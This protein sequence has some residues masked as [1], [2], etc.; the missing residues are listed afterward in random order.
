MAERKI[1]LEDLPSN[2]FSSQPP[3]EPEPII[4]VTTG[5]VKRV[6]SDGLL[7]IFVM[8]QLV[9]TMRYCYQHS[10][11][12][13]LTSWRTLLTC[14][15]SVDKTDIVE[16]IVTVGINAAITTCTSNARNHLSVVEWCLVP[17]RSVMDEEIYFMRRPD[18]EAVLA[19]MFERIA[20]YGWVT[21][22]DMYTLSGATAHH[23]A[24]RY[25][26]SN[27]S[28]AN[29]L[30]TLLVGLSIYQNQNMIVRR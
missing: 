27:I 23:T 13:Y 4:A 1:N 15:Y 17:P 6:A 9:Y 11:V 22:G 18:A 30:K 8:L 28:Q 16:S 12:S 2:S 19:Q 21:V 26:W 14:Y 29:V 7:V 3:D 24:E 10:K 20:K 25:G 5:N